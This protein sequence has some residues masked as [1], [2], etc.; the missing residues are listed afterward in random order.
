MSIFH[1]ILTILKLIQKKGVQLKNWIIE[2]NQNCFR[3][4]QSQILH[5]IPRY[6]CHYVLTTDIWLN[7]L[8]EKP[9]W[10]QPDTYVSQFLGYCYCYRTVRHL[11]CLG[12]FECSI[13][14]HMGV[15][16]TSL[17][18][19]PGGL[20]ILNIILTTYCESVPE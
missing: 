18:T 13:P 6:T 11:G 10:M 2:L 7:N 4:E 5:W 19:L 16:V 12:Q 8:L 1:K 3:C 14:F 9:T 20:V 15:D 17:S